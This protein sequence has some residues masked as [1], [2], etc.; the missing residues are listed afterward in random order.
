[1]DAVADGR[2]RGP[3]R[4]PGRG[5]ASDW[6]RASGH[7]AAQNRFF[8]LWTEAGGSA[9]AAARRS[10]GPWGSP[11]DG[12]R[13]RGAVPK[14]QGHPALSR[15]SSS[16][17]WSPPSTDGRYP[18]KREV[19]DRCEVIGRHLQGRSR[20]AGRLVLPIAAPGRTGLARGS[21]AAWWTTIAG[22]APSR[23][24]GTAA[25]SSSSRRWPI[26]SSPGWPTSPSGPTPGRGR[27]QRA[28]RGARPD[29]GRGAPRARG[30][31]A[32]ELRA[33]AARMAAAPSQAEAVGSGP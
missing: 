21:P 29:R 31:T 1:M 7:W 32:R 28:P 9:R 18:A 30:A 33:V 19:G 22:R 20:R 12:A 24:S 8:A 10:R 23:S 3:G 2:H 17:T 4:G 26:P 16:R 27:G 5:R 11:R 25:T 13:A 14:H 6:A 15:R